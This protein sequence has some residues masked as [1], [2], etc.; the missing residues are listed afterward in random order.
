MKETLGSDFFIREEKGEVVLPYDRK[1]VAFAI[2]QKQRT[3]KAIR[4]RATGARGTEA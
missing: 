1:G 4:V 3:V 2:D